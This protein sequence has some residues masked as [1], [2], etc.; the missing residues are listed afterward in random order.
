MIE[1]GSLE[2]TADP[3]KGRCD[4]L[5]GIRKGKKRE[6]LLHNPVKLVSMEKRRESNQSNSS[7]VVA[8]I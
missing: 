2:F 7:S 1:V 6:N 8:A 4:A 3:N 5:Y